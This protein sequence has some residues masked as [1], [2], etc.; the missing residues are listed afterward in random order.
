MTSP[1]QCCP[2]SKTCHPA[3]IASCHYVGCHLPVAHY[4]AGKLMPIRFILVD[5]KNEVISHVATT[6]LR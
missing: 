6:Q 3:Q 1:N 4:N 5:P 2:V